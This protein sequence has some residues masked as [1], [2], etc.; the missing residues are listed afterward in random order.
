[1]LGSS[2]ASLDARGGTGGLMGQGLCK[3]DQHEATSANID[4]SSVPVLTDQVKLAKASFMGGILNGSWFRRGDNVFLGNIK[5]D[6]ISWVPGFNHP[7]CNLT[8][9]DSLRISILLEGKTHNGAVSKKGT[10][11]TIVWSDGE[12][13]FKK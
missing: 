5:D 11:T 4:V 12:V 10:E 3:C 2:S 7:P 6:T 1:S 8:E 9:V 13:W